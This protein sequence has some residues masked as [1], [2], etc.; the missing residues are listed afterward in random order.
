MRW[1]LVLLL[2]GGIAISCERSPVDGPEKPPKPTT[3]TQPTTAPAAVPTSQPTTR[4]VDIYREDVP[5]VGELNRSREE[6]VSKRTPRLVINRPLTVD[7]FGQ[8]WVTH[9]NAR[10]WEQVLAGPITSEAMI[11]RDRVLVTGQHTAGTPKRFV[12]ARTEAGVR[13]IEADRAFA[14]NDDKTRDWAGAISSGS[15]VLVPARSG[16]WMIQLN[17]EAISETFVE[18]TSPGPRRRVQVQFMGEIPL[19]WSEDDT[20]ETPSRAA[21][22]DDA[23]KKWIPLGPET[24]WPEQVAEVFFGARGQLMVVD[25]QS[26]LLRVD[27][28]T[29]T[30]NQASLEL[31]LRELS[32]TEPQLR[33]AATVYL[34][35]LG[36]AGHDAI[37]A[38]MPTADPD[39]R[40]R[41]QIILDDKP[42]LTLDGHRPLPGLATVMHRSADRQW[43]IIR[44]D[45]GAQ[46][47]EPSGGTRKVAPAI[48]IYGVYGKF[49]YVLP[50]FTERL[51]WK[52]CWLKLAGSDLVVEQVDRAPIHWMGMQSSPITQQGEE[53]FS[54]FYTTDLQGRWLLRTPDDDGPTL[55]I[56]TT[57]EK[58]VMLLPYYTIRRD[59]VGGWDAKNRLVRKFRREAWSLDQ[60]GW[61]KPAKAEMENLPLSEKSADEN[62]L[63]SVA[64]SNGKLELPEKLQGPGVIDSRAVV[65]EA[66]GKV[67]V[68]NQPG[69]VICVQPGDASKREKPSVAATFSKGLNV[70]TIQRVWKDPFGRLVVQGDDGATVLFPEGELPE[71]F[72]SMMSPGA[73]RQAREATAD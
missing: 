64:T 31:A 27:L 58:S 30:V 2:L 72:A 54:K 5:Q 45:G 20:R 57:L 36:R 26:K 10:P 15:S 11:V 14:I 21:R 35:Q 65:I 39:T 47:Q 50:H 28:G 70:G 59:E 43:G 71:D 68:F 7:Q 23:T 62:G 32:S 38:A 48:F 6:G 53:D 42:D 24:G 17:G 16:A 9:P 60:A 22:W 69:R 49:T 19:A 34:R 8:L 66:A 3:Q 1:T 33:H 4:L 12:I 51:N 52:F 56:D 44:F 18:L 46:L 41:L 55:I 40:G 73:I 29:A 25:G 63:K 13:W 37:R 67:W 61:V